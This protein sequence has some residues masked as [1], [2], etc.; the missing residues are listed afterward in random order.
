MKCRA[1]LLNLTFFCITNKW[2]NT[3]DK[4][5]PLIHKNT[6]LPFSLQCAVKSNY[7]FNL[8]QKWHPNAMMQ[9]F[10]KTNRKLYYTF[11]KTNVCI[12]SYVQFQALKMCTKRRRCFMFICSLHS[13]IFSQTLIWASKK[14]EQHT[15]SPMSH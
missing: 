11:V 3:W 4:N 6:F 7:T 2:R 10:N 14:K 13:T 9:M 15:H 12:K 5:R 8:S 1:W